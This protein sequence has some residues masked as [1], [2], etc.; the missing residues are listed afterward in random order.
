ME[1]LG[2]GGHMTMAGTRFHNIS[3]DEAVEM[4]ENALK[5]YLNCI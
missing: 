5:E 4:L 1:S 3:M 2:G